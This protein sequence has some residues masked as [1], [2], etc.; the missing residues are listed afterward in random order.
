VVKQW[1]GGPGPAHKLDPFARPPNLWRLAYKTEA[2]ETGTTGV[3]D[4]IVRNTEDRMLTAAYNLQ[5]T[6]AGFLTV[7]EEHP[8][9]YIE[10]SSHGPRWQ[11]AI[12][13]ADD[14]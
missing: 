13:Q 1:S 5:S 14:K 8:E 10:V 2:G 11:V 7:K 12:E 6:A 4:I 3:V 9:Y